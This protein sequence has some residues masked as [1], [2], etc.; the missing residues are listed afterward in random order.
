ML[1]KGLD[2]AVA[3][4][5]AVS[6][7][8]PSDEQITLKIEDASIGLPTIPV[9]TIGVKNTHVFPSECRQRAYTYK[10]RMV[11]NVAWSINGRPQP[12][13]EKD[14][15]EVPIMLRVCTLLFTI[16]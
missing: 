11:I 3:D 9:G 7:K 14:V 10:A 2:E 12:S 13:F 5:Y 15:G 1:D 6:L 4:L 8:L 16:N